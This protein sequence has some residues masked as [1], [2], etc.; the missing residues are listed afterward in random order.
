[1]PAHWQVELGLVPL[2]VRPMSGTTFRGGCEFRMT[3]DC[4]CD[5]IFFGTRAV[6]NMESCHLFLQ[7]IMVIIPLIGDV[8]DVVL[9]RACTGYWMGIPVFFVVVSPLYLLG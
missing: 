1:M 6:F 5:V 9:T 7:Y 2:L 3:L 8:A 4:L